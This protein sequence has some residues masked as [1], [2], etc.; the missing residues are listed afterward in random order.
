V[1]EIREAND[2]LFEHV[3]WLYAFCSEHVF[4]DDTERGGFFN[5]STSILIAVARI[6]LEPSKQSRESK[7]QGVIKTFPASFFAVGKSEALLFT[8]VNFFERF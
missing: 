3:A 6:A 4:R 1:R 8:L 5:H 2:S 7:Q